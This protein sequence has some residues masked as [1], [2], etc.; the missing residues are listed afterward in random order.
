MSAKVNLLPREVAIQARQRRTTALTVVVLLLFVAVLGGLYF[1]KLGVVE[2]ARQDRDAAQ[3]EVSRLRAELAQL[4]EFRLLADRLEA[5]NQLLA[6]AMAN[7]ISWARVLNDLSLTFPANASMRNLTVA[8]PPAHEVSPAPGEITFGDTAATVSYTGYSVERYAPGV[9]VVLIE[10]DQ[11]RGFFN[12]F[13][14]AAQQEL[15]ETTEVTAFNGTVQLN[16][17]SYTG[18]YDNGLPAEVAP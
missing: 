15:I 9:E 4:E 18:R 16:G 8:V 3:A 2:Q 17:E 7:E 5:R 6:F 11:A 1:L 14:D 12:S 13:L 10:F